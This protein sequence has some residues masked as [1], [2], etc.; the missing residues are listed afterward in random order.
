MLRSIRSFGH[1]QPIHS[2]KSNFKRRKSLQLNVVDRTHR[3]QCQ[4]GAHSSHALNLNIESILN[5]FLRSTEDSEMCEHLFI[6]SIAVH[7]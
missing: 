6:E 2:F 3:Q 7:K 4:R 1:P 5:L